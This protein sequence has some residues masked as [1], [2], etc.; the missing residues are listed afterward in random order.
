M[1]A[2][3]VGHVEPWRPYQLLLELVHPAFKDEKGFILTG[4]ICFDATDIALSADLR[5]KSNAYLVSA[6]NQ[7]V[8]TFDSMVEAL[9]YHMSH[10]QKHSQISSST[11]S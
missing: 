4:S 1:M 7:D 2:D 5:D 11:A 10:L 3:E 9:H 8:N 6:L